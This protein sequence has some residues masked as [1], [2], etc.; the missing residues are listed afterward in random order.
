MGPLE[1]FREQ[2]EVFHRRADLAVPEDDRKP[3]DIAAVFQVLS[4]LLDLRKPDEGLPQLDV[5][6]VTFF[7]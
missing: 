2:M 7:R 1:V 4:R 6:G 3:D 5:F